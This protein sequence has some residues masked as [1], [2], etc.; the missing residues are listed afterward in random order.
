MA[1]NK[2]RIKLPWCVNTSWCINT[3][4]CAKQKD[5]NQPV[6]RITETTNQWPAI[7]QQSTYVEDRAKTSNNHL[8]QQ[9]EREGKQKQK[10][11]RVTQQQLKQQT[12]Y[13][14]EGL[15]MFPRLL[16]FPCLL[17]FLSLLAFRCLLV[18]WCLLVSE[19]ER[20]NKS[21]NQPV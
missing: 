9:R 7:K 13:L 21:D 5:N 20:K 19:A 17:V 12:A 16:T 4:W 11:N 14:H 2:T 10:L 3:S 18:S 15:L 8:L 1:K 6:E